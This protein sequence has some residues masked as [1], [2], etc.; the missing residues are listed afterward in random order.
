MAIGLLSLLS[1]GA[2]AVVGANAALGVLL[3]G[4]VMLL[5]FALGGLAV[6][7]LSQAA[8]AGMTGGGAGLSMLKLPALVMAIWLLLERFDPIAVVIGG[9]VV[10]ISVVLQASLETLSAVPEDAR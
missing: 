1:V 7:R 8:E 4:V 3:G 5:S 9:S 10:M 6:R 2:W